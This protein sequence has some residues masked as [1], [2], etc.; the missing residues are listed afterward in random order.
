MTEMRMEAGIDDSSGT[1]DMLPQNVGVFKNFAYWLGHPDT[2]YGDGW[3]ETMTLDPIPIAATGADFTYLT[4]DYYAEGD[5]LQDSNGNILA[6]RDAANLEIS[7]T[8]E[9]E[10]IP[11]GSL[12]ELE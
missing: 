9:G 4:F 2:G 11:G 6:I 3:N 5:F 8:K 12:R 10:L 1:N 7:W